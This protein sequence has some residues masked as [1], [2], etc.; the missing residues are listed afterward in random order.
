MNKIKRLPF[1]EQVM[2][3][4]ILVLIFV[5]IVSLIAANTTKTF[6]TIDLVNKF[7]SSL[8][9]KGQTLKIIAFIILI[10][11]LLVFICYWLT[12]TI[13]NKHIVLGPFY[14]ILFIF[15]VLF[16]EGYHVIVGVIDVYYVTLIFLN[17]VSLISTIISFVKYLQIIKKEEVVNG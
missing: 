13:I 9:F 17:I 4:N 11:L 6:E 15:S 7:I 16:K 14:L 5:S 10:L 12:N 1:Y 8:L 3:Y 2:L